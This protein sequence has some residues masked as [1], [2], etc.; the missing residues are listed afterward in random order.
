MHVQVQIELLNDIAFLLY[1]EKGHPFMSLYKMLSIS[2]EDWIS[3]GELE[4]IQTP[5]Y[6]SV[7]CAVTQLVP[8]QI[9]CLP[10]NRSSMSVI[11]YLVLLDK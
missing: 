7:G 8:I 10:C 1:I 3:K 11:I 4:L 5:K 2:M 9:T 6:G